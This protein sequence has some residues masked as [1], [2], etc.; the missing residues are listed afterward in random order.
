MPIKESAVKELRKSKKR[1][2][3]NARVLVTID[4]LGRQARKAIA[5]KTPDAATLLKT[6]QKTLD[7][8]VKRGIIKKNT[9]SRLKSRLA[10]RLHIQKA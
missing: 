3:I 9:A 2:S 10:K 6:I 7:K 5:A 8:A 4:R 1:A